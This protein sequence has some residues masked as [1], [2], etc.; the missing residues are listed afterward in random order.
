MGE[1]KSKLG[2]C[3]AKI[4]LKIKVQRTCMHVYRS[5]SLFCDY[6]P[7]FVS[8]GKW[9]ITAYLHKK[10]SYLHTLYT[11]W[12]NPHTH[13][14]TFIFIFHS[15]FSRDSFSLQLMHKE[16]RLIPLFLSAICYIHSKLLYAHARHGLIQEFLWTAEKIL[17]PTVNNN[18]IVGEILPLQTK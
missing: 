9:N 14:T 6:S 16:H 13:A 4:T 10:Y 15:I 2:T 7:K 11:A 8:A 12:Q 18:S 3:E 17:N 5:C 1:K